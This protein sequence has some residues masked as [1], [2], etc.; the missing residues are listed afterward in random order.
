MAL[1]ISVLR[2][3]DFRL[4]LA[5]RLLAMVALQAQAVIVGWQVYTLTH[6]PFMLGL[7]GLAEAVPALACAL[8]SG[9]WV[10]VGKPYRIYV[11]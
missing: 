1:S 5:T 4:L 10:D 6:D 11:S 9:H 7:V 8:F 3:H 2:N